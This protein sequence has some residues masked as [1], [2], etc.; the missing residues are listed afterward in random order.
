MANFVK[1]ELKVKHTF[2]QRLKRHYLNDIQ[3]VYHCHHYSALYTQL[4]IDAN[5][6]ALLATAAE[7]NFYVMLINYFKE[8]NVE[9]I[10]LKVILACEYYSVLGLG[11]LTVDVLSNNMSIVSSENSHIE[12]GWIKK[13]KNY[14]K[15][16]NYIGCGYV[17]AMLSAVL[18]HP[19]GTFE[20]VELQ[21]I[22]MGS[23]KTIFK[24]Y[25][26]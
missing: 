1:T 6:E 17:S 15:P 21:S 2:N 19:I 23:E 25:V 8:N 24:S 10:E 22:V 16:V 5:E 13:W 11:S 4:A 7:E 3:S 18:N 20:T 12:L 14:D 9:D 26:K